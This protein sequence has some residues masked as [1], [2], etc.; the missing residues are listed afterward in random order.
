MWVQS[1]ALPLASGV[2]SGKFL[3]L[4]FVSKMIVLIVA[5]LQCCSENYRQ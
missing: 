1:P 5:V 3:K 4:C 2:T